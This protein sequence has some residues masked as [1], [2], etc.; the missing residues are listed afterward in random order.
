[1]PNENALPY[2]LLADWVSAFIAQSERPLVRHCQETLKAALLLSQ[3]L[4]AN[5]HWQ[6]I[7]TEEFYKRLKEGKNIH[8]WNC[9]FWGDWS[10]NCEA[11]SIMLCWRAIE[12]INPTVRAI[13]QRDHIA[14]AILARSLLELVSSYLINAN[15]IHSSCDGVARIEDKMVVSQECEDF[16]VKTIWGRRFLNP[17]EVHKQINALTSLQR[18][19][20]HPDANEL[21]PT[22]ELLCEV[23]HPNV[24]GYARFWS[25]NTAQ[26]TDGS[27]AREISRLATGSTQKEILENTIWALSFGAGSIVNGYQLIHKA[28]SF[29]IPWIKRETG[30]CHK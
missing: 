9:E 22:Y 20:K 16:I 8:C 6:T 30:F 24:V 15:F 17:D 11:Y 7:S 1:M 3:V 13:N 18:L 10:K 5:Y 23:A 19:N 12:I 27:V 25:D 28:V 14:A 2:T 29:L 26:N 21:M 4:P